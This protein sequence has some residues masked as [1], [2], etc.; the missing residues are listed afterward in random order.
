MSKKR[1]IID[2]LV[3]KHHSNIEDLDDD[4]TLALKTLVTNIDQAEKT[5]VTSI[6]SLLKN[7]LNSNIE[8]L[9]VD[10]RSN[11]ENLGGE[12]HSNIYNI[13]GLGG[14]PRARIEDL[15]SGNALAL[16]QRS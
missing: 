15:V 3:G 6:S 14:E 16:K 5:F 8:D 1:S 4:N 12:Q 13:E 11:I 7:L 10:H 9:C 2:G